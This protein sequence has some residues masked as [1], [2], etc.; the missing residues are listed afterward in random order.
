MA[1]LGLLTKNRLGP[2]TIYRTF[3]VNNTLSQKS[4]GPHRLFSKLIIDGKTK[5]QIEKGAKVI[6]NGYLSMGIN[7]EDFFPSTALGTLRIAENGK[8]VVN[9]NLNI[10]RG[11]IIEAQKNANLEFGNNVC[12][13]S[14]VTIIAS[15]SIK[16]GD[17][18][19]IGWNSEIIDNDYHGMINNGGDVRVAKPIEIG[20]HVFI[21]RHVCIMK[22]VKIGDGSVIAAGAI[23]TH[24]VASN[25]LAGG[26]PARVIKENIQWK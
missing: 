18:T 23:V 20:S 5:V 14:N 17:N 2:R 9:G 1:N 24:D 13:N 16:I 11:V 21:A 3:Q 4:I 19:G 10:G 7:P 15:Q 26:I 22:G 12:I 25:C 8:L 6:I